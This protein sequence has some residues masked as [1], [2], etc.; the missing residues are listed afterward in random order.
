MII[1]ALLLFVVAFAHVSM[2]PVDINIK[3]L[4]SFM[5]DHGGNDTDMWLAYELLPLEKF[6]GIHFGNLVLS[7]YPTNLQSVWRLEACGDSY[8]IC[9]KRHNG[10]IQ[11]DY[12][13]VCEGP[14]DQ[15]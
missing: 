5:G 2:P 10:C 4:G 7:E 13:T 11:F 12:E 15:G 14:M 6:D 9:T 1:L 3:V 8:A